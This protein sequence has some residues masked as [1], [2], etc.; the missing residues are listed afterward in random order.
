[1]PLVGGAF[2]GVSLA[3]AE[4]VGEMEGG[5]AL[6]TDTVVDWSELELV[7]EPVLVLWIEAMVV[8]VSG[9][10][11]LVVAVIAGPT[12]VVAVVLT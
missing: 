11:L 8:I 2:G 10:D 9:V 7:P 12:E 3:G 1:M 6:E 4:F 5:L